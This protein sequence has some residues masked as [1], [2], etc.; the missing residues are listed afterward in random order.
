M[1]KGKGGKSKGF[2][3]QGVHSSVSS[4]T[5]AAVRADYKASGD[6]LINQL[7]ASRKGRRTMITIEN[8]N[9]E[10]T[11]RRFIRIEGKQW[12]MAESAPEKTKK[13]NNALASEY[14]IT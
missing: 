2:I 11:N 4:S 9:R 1:A 6:R 10:E 8:P 3:S 13:K 12:F 5:K 14:D 7:N